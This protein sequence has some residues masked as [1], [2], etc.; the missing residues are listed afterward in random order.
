[1]SFDRTVGDHRF[2]FRREVCVL[3]GISRAEFEEGGQPRCEG[4]AP[5]MR[6]RFALLPITILRRLHRDTQA[7]LAAKR[8]DENERC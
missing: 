1:M 7:R 4:Q 8:G 2:A 5:D 3:C 6:E